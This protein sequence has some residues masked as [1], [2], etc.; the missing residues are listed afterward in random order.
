[1]IYIDFLPTIPDGLLPTGGDPDVDS[2]LADEHGRSVAMT[3]D[4]A[5]MEHL[6]G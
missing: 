4:P 6:Q 2:A 1:M 5:T 3:D